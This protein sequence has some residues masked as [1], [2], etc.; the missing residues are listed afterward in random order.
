MTDDFSFF[1]WAFKGMVSIGLTV[2]GWFWIM[3]FKAVGKNR[4]D[5]VDHKL[6]VSDN[7]IKKDVVDRIHERIDS[8]DGKMDDIKD[9]LIN[10]RNHS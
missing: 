5:L 8:V 4:D 2:G 9:I 10:M 3:L 1:E 7:Y 6:H